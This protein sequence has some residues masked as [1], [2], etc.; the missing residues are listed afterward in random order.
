MQRLLL[1]L[2]AL[3]LLSAGSYGQTWEQVFSKAEKQ[4]AKGKY[5]KVQKQIDK[6]R[7]KHIKK[8][9][10]DD[11]S[12]YPLTYVMEAKSRK[13]MADYD[14]MSA[15]IEKALTGLDQ[16]EIGHQYNYTMGLL[17]LVD[18]YLDYGN[19]RKADSIQSMAD[20]LSSSYLQSEVLEME[21]KIRRALVDIELGRYN[22]AKPIL[23][24]LI[25][26]WPTK[27]KISYAY[28]S[29]TSD[30]ETYKNQL[31][32]R[33]F[34]A[35]VEILRRKGEYAKAIDLLDLRGKQ[36]NRLVDGRSP[37]YVDFRIA[38][39]N[40]YLDYGNSSEA[41]KLA[42]RITAL[43]PP[44]RLYE[45]AADV[46]IRACLEEE[47]FTD[48]VGTYNNLESQLIKAH[49][50]RDYAYL[51]S[52][53]YGSLLR[54]YEEDPNQNVAVRINGLLSKSSSLLPADHRIRTDVVQA[55]LDY[56]FRTNRSQNYPIAEKFYEE[57]GKSLRLRYRANTL[58]LNIYKVNYA[59]YY[60]KYSENPQKAYQMLADEPY[61]Q[62]LEELSTVHPD[63]VRMV[64]DLM[65]YFTIVGNFDYPIKLT[66][67]VVDAMRANPN[68]EKEELGNKLVEL[69]R[70][71][72]EGGYYKDAEQNTDE[73]LK[74]I[75]RGG[76]RKSEEF[77]NALNN[78][79]YL[80]GTIGLYSKAINQ[81]NKAESIYNRLATANKEL[82]F[83]SITDL[84]FL[85]TRMGKYS[86]TQE[87][88][89]EV[90]SERKKIYKDNSRRLIE[91][92]SALGE[93]FL[94]KGDYPEAESNFRKS[95]KIAE[96]VFGDSTLLFAK[97][98]S[99]MVKLYVELGNYQAA[100]V[101]ATDV[102][103]IRQKVLRDGHILL[104]DTYNDLGN[105]HY[106][107]GSDLAVVDK[108]YRLAKDITESNF[109][110]FHPLYAESLKN[111][112][113]VHV[114]RKEYDEALKLLNQA[115][116]IW[117][118]ALSNLNKSSGEVARIKGDIYSF[119][120]DFKEA[121]KEYERAAR[122]FKI[123]FSDQHPDYL[124]TQSR[125]ARAYY[126][127]GELNKVEDILSETTTSYLA[128]T[129]EYFPTLSEEEKSKF[130][131]KIKPDFE[132][133]NT[134][135][136]AYSQ[137]KEKYLENMY[138]FAL[139]TKGLL[140][141]SSRKTR[142]SIM[143][144]GNAELIELFKQWVEKKEYLT[145]TVAQSE[146]QLIENQVDI[147]K[148]KDEIA[149]LEKQ[150]SSISQEFQDS[151]EFQ[152]YSW[153]DIRKSL[154]D[155]EAA[156][157]IIRYREFDNKFNEDSIR[158]AALI[159]TA[160]TKRNPELVLLKNGKEMEGKHFQYHRN[161]TKYKIPDNRS[162][163]IYW[164]QIHE[165]I[166]DKDV[167]Y[168]SPDGIYNQLNVESLLIDDTTFVID[169]Q[170]VRVINNSRTIAA[171]RS[172][173]AR[174]E[175]KK[176]GADENMTALLMGNPTY[177]EN[178]ANKEAAIKKANSVG[179]GLVQQL[180][181]TETEVNTITKLLKDKGW[182]TESYLGSNAT[183]EQIKRAQSYTLIHIA[184]HG[185][186][187]DQTKKGKEPELLFEE[188]DNPL[189]RAG[190]LTEG[191]GDVLVNATKNYNIQDG[192]L[193]AYEAMSLNFDQTELIV[194]SACETG[195]GEIQQGEGV[196]GLQRSFLV[197]GADAIIMSLFQV[198]DEVTQQLMVEFYNN[199]INGQDKRTAF[200]NAQR[201]IKKE[202]NDPIYWGAFTMIA[203]I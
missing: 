153:N 2:I 41:R 151:Y 79:A 24:D 91:P 69:A 124:N 189:E 26:V 47:K 60:L 113:F 3:L 33:M 6:L 63:Y 48:A 52:N 132:F 86:E 89:N 169:L 178:D 115:D 147:P 101:N 111:V 58:A 128:Y 59:G 134:I 19:F 154:E 102:L 4:F 53:Y 83:N 90:I 143:N 20:E 164:Q 145:T 118:D 57:L 175:A 32:V 15:S 70:L 105:I 122:Y 161:A 46:D 193:T 40:T 72:I 88:L 110:Q 119:T 82:K 97:N 201:K 95:V 81:L 160:D 192:I 188:D 77:V 76:E 39:A 159:V 120:G 141:S 158:Y 100:L 112:A 190:L 114:Q 103:K 16:Q 106:Y 75:R 138:D 184:T 182:Y 180:P 78:A 186:F 11:P 136:V 71:Q 150:L 36:V 25:K 43:K 99:Y 137:S 61:K 22:E 80:Y 200:N 74:L 144:S 140:L 185:F 116:E 62:A 179:Q 142:N 85:Y 157:E 168:L 92:Y 13:A 183:E 38:E 37:A 10:Q 156:V 7:E 167:V 173:E 1:S 107:L 45:K 12:L 67:Q 126:I 49:V 17:R 198:S 108:Y 163:Q 191:G 94:I 73:A 176:A 21:V 152:L 199:W 170:N 50:K 87:L 34:A 187:Q 9:Y 195:R 149:V 196:F 171:L 174:K 131:N 29:V 109:G 172:R 135:A 125:L 133:Y 68:T 202:F 194:L 64:N 121:R 23:D 123:L 162:Y 146:E 51:V 5:H 18:I 56:I 84:A 14:G 35:E 181:G 177:Y 96:T 30:D 148:L 42:G 127:N 165:V 55:A 117:R 130:W 31:L 28:E 197:A 155:N 104:A 27:M 54:T 8:K 44:G 166:K 129:K 139:T 203:K 93:M 65:E 98:L 66:Q